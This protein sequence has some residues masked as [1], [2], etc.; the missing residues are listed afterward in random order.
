MP[1]KPYMMKPR[2]MRCPDGHFRHTIFGLGPYIVDY[3]EQVW[4]AGI[5]STWCPNVGQ[6]FTHLF[7]CTDI[8]ELLTPDLLHQLIKG[9]FKD[10]LVEW[11]L[12]Y[13]HLTHREKVTLETIEDIDHCDYLIASGTH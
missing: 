8:H 9:V 11:V 13:L 1:L 7:L 2:V 10:H 5:V 6:P 12:E 3:P 4:L